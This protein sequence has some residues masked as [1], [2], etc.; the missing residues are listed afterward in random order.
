MRP[1]LT[2]LLLIPLLAIL[3]RDA[4]GLECRRRLL[5][6]DE[7]RTLEAFVLES[8]G[9][10]AD[11]HSIQACRDWSVV[12]I[13]TLRVPQPDGTER[14]GML[15]C[16]PMRKS[17]PERWHCVGDPSNGF[18]ADTYP[19]E[20]GVWVSIATPTAP[21]L[22]RR[23]VALG[24]DRLGRDGSIESCVNGADGARTAASLRAEITADAGYV[25]LVRE[26]HRFSLVGGDVIVYFERDSEETG[27]VTCWMQEEVLVTS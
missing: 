20:L 1:R 7:Q 27:H 24:F 19:G 6:D 11:P 12:R 3:A 16:Y 26:P 8:T 10:P 2:R 21:G 5:T 25:L 17:W 14:F 13:D 4:L 9:L 18:R 23:L 15:S 22:A